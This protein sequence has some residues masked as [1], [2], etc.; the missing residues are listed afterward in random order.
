M[1]PPSEALFGGVVMNPRIIKETLSDGSKVF[2][3][4]FE[5]GSHV[6]NLHCVDE[7]GALR[8]QQII[9]KVVIDSEVI[10]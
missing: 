5:T 9:E 6:V 1:G 4:Q 7:W 3:V 10:V 8:L 2:S